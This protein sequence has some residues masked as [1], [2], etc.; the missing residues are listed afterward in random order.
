MV[1]S[2]TIP[3]HILQ[4]YHIV[5][6]SRRRE[7]GREGRGGKGG[8]K[9]EDIINSLTRN[10]LRHDINSLLYI[11]FTCIEK[12]PTTK[13]IRFLYLYSLEYV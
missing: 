6:D 8:V 7:G 3:V 9:E 10:Q 12:V 2:R 11:V 13:F 4:S 1:L 5:S